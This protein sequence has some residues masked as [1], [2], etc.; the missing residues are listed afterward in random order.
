MC[1]FTCVYVYMYVC[2]YIY[3]HILAA[4]PWHV[5]RARSHF[6]S[7]FF[8]STIWVPRIEVRSWNLTISPLPSDLSCSPHSALIIWTIKNQLASVLVIYF[9][10]I[11][12]TIL[13]EKLSHLYALPCASLLMFARKVLK[14]ICLFDVVRVWYINK[15]SNTLF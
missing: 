11:I 6:E 3:V 15:I 13:K 12:N 10:I 2:I 9:C 14:E 8:P 5:Y 4:L 1:L 7:T